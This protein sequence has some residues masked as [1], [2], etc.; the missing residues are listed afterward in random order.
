ML[1]EFDKYNILIIG[2]SHKALLT[3]FASLKLLRGIPEIFT[4]VMEF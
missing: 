4:A 1:F 3:S 2:V